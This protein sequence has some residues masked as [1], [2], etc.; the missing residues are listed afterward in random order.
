MAR[1]AMSVAL[2]WTGSKVVARS[3]YAWRCVASS[4]A[5]VMFITV[6]LGPRGWH[7]NDV[8]EAPNLA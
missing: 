3:A 8:P 7:G 4:A 1:R 5:L 6:L 2:K